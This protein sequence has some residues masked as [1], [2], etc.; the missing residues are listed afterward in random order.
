MKVAVLGG[1]PAGLY[2]SLLMKKAD[3]AHEVVLCERNAPDATFGWGV[4][5]SDQT[6]G[7]FKAADPESFQAISDNFARWDDIDIH[8]KGRTITSGGHGFAGIARMKLLEILQRRAA[9]LGVDLRFGCEVHDDSA[10]AGLGLGDAGVVVAADGINSAVRRRHAEELRPDLVAGRAKF[11][12]LGT[13]RRF[14]A[15]TFVFV[16]TEHGIF[17]AHAYRFSET[18]SAFIVECDEA[19]WR[20]A[21]FDRMDVDA[22][23]AACEKMFGP[24][25]DGHP[26]LA[27][28]P[29]AQRAAPWLNF[30][31]VH[32]QRWWQGNLVLIGDAAHTAH[33]SIGSGTKLAME[34]AIALARIL[35][36]P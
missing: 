16:E 11:V 36:G 8:Y 29:P 28:I 31:R 20:H 13:T 12:W 34:D 14:D 18:H 9:G 27:N 5:F 23:I 2:F 6:L 1:G 24:W 30:T 21:G 10:L 7:N 33:F 15:F 26:L 3:P 19:S 17:Q 35:N 32:C 25:L 4:V 22:T